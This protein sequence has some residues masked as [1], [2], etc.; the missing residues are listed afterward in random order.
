MA[1]GFENTAPELLPTAIKAPPKEA[2]DRQI[3]IRPVISGTPRKSV[4]N[5]LYPFQEYH[6]TFDQKFLTH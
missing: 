5:N 2:R 1:A 4:S 6:L 3:K